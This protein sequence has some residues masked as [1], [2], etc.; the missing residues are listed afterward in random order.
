MRAVIY[1]RVSSL[2]Q[3]DNLSLDTQEKA[4]RE[5]CAQHDY[6]VDAVF[7]ERGESAKTADRTEFLK[8]LEHCRRASRDRVHAVV[9]YSLTRFSR[10]TTDHHAI[11]AGLRGLGIIL[12][13]VTEPIDE[14]PTGKLME[15]MLAGFAQ[16]DNDVKA[17]RVRAGLKAAVERGRWCWPAPIGYLNADA[18]R[19]PSLVPDPERAPL[20]RKAFE[21]HDAGVRGR[22]LLR[23]VH[24][25]GLRAKRGGTP[26]SLATLYNVLHH[27]A[28]IGIVRPRGWTEDARGDFEPLVDVALFE[29]VQA[30]LHTKPRQSPAIGQHVDHPDFPL[31]RFVR[32]SCGHAM[33]GSWSS[34]RSRRH[35]YYHCQKSCQRITKAALEGAFFALLDTLRPEAAGWRIIEHVVFTSLRTAQQEAKSREA[36]ARRAMTTIEARRRH[37]DDAYLYDRTI[38]AATYTA[39]RERLEGDL[40]VARMDA[41]AAFVADVDIDGQLAFARTALERA[42]T[43]WTAASDVQERIALQWTLFPEG[44][45]LRSAAA[46]AGSNRGAPD[47]ADPFEPPVTCLSFFEIGKRAGEDSRMV[48]REGPTWNQ[49]RHWLAGLTA[50]TAA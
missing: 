22:E 3:V 47:L 24:A 40:I 49:V 10:N 7:I 4:C 46:D 5:Y 25:L 15:A 39:Q 6:D 33:T 48:H 35:A 38:D 11:A 50:L 1:C 2:T 41:S 17:A 13:S 18:S 28:Y 21:L 8:L 36:A 12:R 29:R 23:Q 20:V 42:S 9:V 37:L 14:S 32:C 44:L 19:G 16:F 30:S 26:L 31:R 27:R 43:L 45:Q 34:G